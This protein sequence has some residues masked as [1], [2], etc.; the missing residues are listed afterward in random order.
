VRLHGESLPQFN[1]GRLFHLFVGSSFIMVRNAWLGTAAAFFVL[2]LSLASADPKDKSNLQGTW[3]AFEA[4]RDGQAAGELK[5]HLLTLKGERFTV[6]KGTETLYQGTFKFDSGRKPP[7][8]DFRHSE[9]TVRGKTWKGI[10]RLEDDYLLICDN[11]GGVDRPRPSSFS[12]KADSGY[13][14]ITFK[15]EKP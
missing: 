5:G 2:G 10:Y 4:E 12:T 14:L 1:V 6:K 3:K 9:G 11:A 15:K 8:I 7:T 13:V